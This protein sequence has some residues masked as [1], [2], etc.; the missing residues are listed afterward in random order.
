MQT[1]TVVVVAGTTNGYVA[2]EVLAALG[3]AEKFSPRR[4]F[5]GITLPPHAATTDRGVLPDQSKFPGDVALVNGQWQIGKTLFD[6]CESLRE[7]DIVVKGANAINPATR[8]AGVLIGHPQGGTILAALQAAIGR[9]V[10]LLLPVGLEKRVHTD[11]YELATR[12]NV[13]GAGGPR[14][15]PVP[16]E[17]ITE[18]EALALLTGVQAE[19][20]AGGGVGGAEGS[21]WLAARGSEEQ[22]ENARALMAEVAGEA[23][24]V[25]SEPAHKQS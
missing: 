16:G 23:P 6:V 21:V 14:L 2:A 12:L 17:I 7:G 18:I 1:G 5:R 25:L 9:R 20:V 10:R 8:Q 19:L 11:L 13:P 24:F 3:Q 15:L 4:F 22:I